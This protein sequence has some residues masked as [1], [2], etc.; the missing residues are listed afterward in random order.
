MLYRDVRIARQAAH[1]RKLDE[2]KVAARVDAERQVIDDEPQ[3]RMSRGN[4][5]DLLTEVGA[6]T[7]IGMP[8]RSA[9]GHNQSAVPS[10][11][12]FRCSGM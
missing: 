1:I 6:Y 4:L 8:Q 9:I 5:F 2:R 12:I 7:M 3:P 10:N 11:S